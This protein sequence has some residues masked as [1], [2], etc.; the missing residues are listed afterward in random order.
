MSLDRM[1]CIL[2]RD[3][4]VKGNDVKVCSTVYIVSHEAGSVLTTSQDD[5]VL[6]CRRI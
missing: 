3:V 6:S 1:G 4:G 2:G 5:N